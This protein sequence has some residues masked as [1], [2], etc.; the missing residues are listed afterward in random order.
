MLLNEDELDNLNNLESEN[1]TMCSCYDIIN[2]THYKDYI[3]DFFTYKFV[4]N[5]EYKVH[6][7][8]Y[9]SMVDVNSSN[10]NKLYECKVSYYKNNLDNL[11]S[12]SFNLE[13]TNNIDLNSTK[14]LFKFNIFKNN[15]Q[16]KTI[17]F[18]YKLNTY[19]YNSDII[20]I[21]F[22]NHHVYLYL[23]KNKNDKL[24]ISKILFHIIN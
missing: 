9:D 2:K 6:C 23:Q 14:G 5:T 10:Y 7:Y 22:S 20:K 8:I 12:N 18:K 15:N 21:L 13:L 4:N 1:N 24:Y 16:I 3:T 19:N 11:N 17:T